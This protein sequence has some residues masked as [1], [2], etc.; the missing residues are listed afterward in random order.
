MNRKLFMLKK[1]NVL[2]AAL[3]I[4]A[5]ICWCAGTFT[6][7]RSRDSL[8]AAAARWPAGGVS[9]AQLEAQLE[10]FREDRTQGVPGLTLWAQHAAQSVT[11]GEEKTLRVPVLELYGPVENLRSDRYLSGGAPARGSTKTCSVSEGAA[12]ALWGGANVTGQTLTWKG[13][14]YAVQGVFKDEE[15]L[16]IVQADAGS[17]A[18]F[19]NMQL[20]FS[21][22]AGR[23]AA[24]EFLNRTSFGSPQLL[25]MPLIGWAMGL[26]AFLPALLIGLWLLARL[27][28]HGLGARKNARKLLHYLP[29]AILAAG[30][31]IFLLSRGEGV[32][33]ALIPSRW[34]DFAFWA[35]LAEEGAKR[36]KTWLSMPQAGDIALLFSLL[37]TA[38]AV[39][40]CLLAMSVLL[41]KARVE[42]PLHAL[43]ACGGCVLLVFLMAAFYADRGGLHVNLAMWLMPCLWILTDCALSWWKGGTAV[44]AKTEL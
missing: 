13:Q 44:E 34:S 40:A 32:P 29:P 10:I 37:G 8:Q 18:V 3:A 19:P 20:Y 1:R 30:M 17:K 2:Y 16:V 9:P 42:K 26:L 24:E 7:Q 4:A 33:A 31:D 15:S 22:N 25:D 21:N 39:F 28:V 5:L 12:F 36:L 27:V 35:S 38:L 41:G 6:A 14:D 11:D 43:L 23:Q